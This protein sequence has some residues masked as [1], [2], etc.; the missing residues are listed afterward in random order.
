MKGFSELAGRQSKLMK[1][2]SASFTDLS[3]NKVSSSSDDEKLSR[4]KADENTEEK[5]KIEWKFVF[6]YAIKIKL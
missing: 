4:A 5:E 6:N 1:G 3:P 2:F